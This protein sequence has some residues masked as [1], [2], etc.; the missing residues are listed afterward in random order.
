MNRHLDQ[1]SALV[2]VIGGGSWGT[3]LAIAL[4]RAGHPVALVVRDHAQAD[5][6][7]RT[8]RNAR[9]LPQIPLPKNIIATANSASELA[10]S[11]LIIYALPCA[12]LAQTLPKLA[13]LNAP[14][15]AA[16][17]GLDQASGQR[18]DTMLLTALGAT[19][20]LLLSGP[21]FADEV[22]AN[23]PTA[24][25]LAATDLHT[26]LDAARFFAESNLRIYP[27]DDL[28][29][30]ALGGALKNIIAIAAGIAQGLNLGHNAMAALVT[31]GIA[32]I[33]RLAVACGARRET[34]HGLSGLG[35]LVLTCN[36]GQSRNRRLG[37]A[38]AHGKS[39][40]EARS[41]I[42][43]VVEGER[44]AQMA[45]H[46]AQQHHIDVPIIASVCAVLSGTSNASQALQQLMARPTK[47]EFE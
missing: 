34:L 4:A 16:C 3:A 24:I 15:I 43:Q 41:A 2:S 36:G 39:L 37:E 26:A 27:H 25:T 45:Q 46:L 11:A 5:A 28:T 8:Q 13:P 17:K 47:A 40:I 7:N 19:R 20:S 31:R 18:V 33:T 10:A 44:T 21:S 23:K 9:Y 1:T 6:I 30:V 14:V 12:I 35:D 42:G 38:L 32:E 29:G 22:A